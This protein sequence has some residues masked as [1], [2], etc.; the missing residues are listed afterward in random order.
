LRSGETSVFRSSPDRKGIRAIWSYSSQVELP[1]F[2]IP[3]G[4]LRFARITK[5]IS[6]GKPL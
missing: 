6:G 4:N 2:V 1:L 3:E 5:A